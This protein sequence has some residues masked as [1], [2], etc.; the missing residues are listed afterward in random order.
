MERIFKVIV[1]LF[2]LIIPL[3][4]FAQEAKQLGEVTAVERFIDGNDKI[5]VI[6]IQD[7]D[8]PFVSIYFTT[9]KSGQFF[10]IAD[11]SNTSIATRLTSAVPVDKNGKQ[12]INKNTV[13]EL[14]TISK[15]IGTKEMKVARWY[16]AEKNTLVYLVYTTKWIGGSLKHSI[17]AVALGFPPEK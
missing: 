2:F 9:I 7:P 3:F 11:P 10:A 13:T 12:I 16:D 4:T 5:K 17:S 1:V 14:A 15:S 6:R 8:N